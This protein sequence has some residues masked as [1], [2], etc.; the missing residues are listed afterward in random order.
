[1]NRYIPSD[2]FLIGFNPEKYKENLN[3]S[4]TFSLSLL[5]MLII[6]TIAILCKNIL[7]W[8]MMFFIV[9]CFDNDWIPY[10]MKRSFDFPLLEILHKRFFSMI[11]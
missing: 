11:V 3:S 5:F 10:E 7:C 4:F 9:S 6:D 1:M 8:N 2:T